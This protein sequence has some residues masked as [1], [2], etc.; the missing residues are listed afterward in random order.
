[1]KDLASLELPEKDDAD[2]AAQTTVNQFRALSAYASHCL[3]QP[4]IWQ[5]FRDTIKIRPLERVDADQV[6]KL[7]VNSWNTERLLRITLETFSG[8][9]NG[10]VAQWSFPQAYYS[11]FNSTLA[12]FTASGFNE[13]SHAAVRKKMSKLAHEKKL[14][15]LLNVYAEGSKSNLKIHGLESTIQDFKSCRLDSSNFEEVK[16]HLRSFFRTTRTQH[17][18]EKKPHLKFETK[19]GKRQKK[20]LN[21]QDWQKVSEAVGHTSWMCL[22]YRKRIQSNYRDIETF[23]SPSF[24]VQSVLEGLVSFVDV[25][26]LANEINLV[27]HFGESMLLKWAPKGSDFVERRMEYIA[28]NTQPR[29]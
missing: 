22:L 27:N 19:D 6:K 3:S 5:R 12:S 15:E 10:F 29:T 13:T 9:E 26:N 25:F 8:P 20:N 17:L 11:V 1:M 4:E 21:E 7:L 16:Q 14:P 28:W 23:L 24:H 18:E 2:W